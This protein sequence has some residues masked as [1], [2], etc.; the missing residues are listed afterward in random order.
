MADGGRQRDGRRRLD[1]DGLLAVSGFRVCRPPSAVRRQ[2]D[3]IAVAL[4][5]R[6]L[7]CIGESRA[8]GGRNRE[9]VGDDEQLLRLREI[10]FRRELVQ[11][12]RFAVGHHAHKTLR[13]QVFDDLRVCDLG[14]TFQRERDQ[15][16]R[17]LGQ[18][19]RRIRGGLGGVGPQ[20]AAAHGAEGAADAR[21]EEPQI[22][23]D[24]RRGADRGS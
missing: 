19:E 20:I 14:G 10:R 9:P 18:R 12:Q 15:H 22:V 1:G 4:D 2:G 17:S 11:V 5:E 7:E 6:G 8:V 24:L 3:G 13:L 21:P 16:A 23:V